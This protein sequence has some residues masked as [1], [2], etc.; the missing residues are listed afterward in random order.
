MF[1]RYVIG[2][3]EEGRSSLGQQIG[4]E[5]S[6]VD[7]RRTK[8]GELYTG[9][10]LLC[11]GSPSHHFMASFSPLHPHSATQMSGFKLGGNFWFA[12]SILL[13]VLGLPRKTDGG[14][15]IFVS[16]LGGKKILPS[17]ETK[18]NEGVP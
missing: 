8:H 12:G 13:P 10:T 9:E 7:Q 15:S 3:A 18:Y 5:V 16:L 4:T 1:Y 14:F 11:P 17:C 2:M 6:V